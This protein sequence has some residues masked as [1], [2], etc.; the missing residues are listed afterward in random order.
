[1]AFH[2]SVWIVAGTA[3]PVVAL[4]GI[5][6]LGDLMEKNER[7]GEQAQA[8]RIMQAR[9]LT[10]AEISQRNML[11]ASLAGYSTMLYQLFIAQVV[12]VLL[13]ALLLAASLLSLLI[14]SNLVPPWLA[15]IAAFGGLVAIGIITLYL[16]SIARAMSRVIS[17]QYWDEK[18]KRSGKGSKPAR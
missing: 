6:S 11:I 13:Q 18:G 9:E 14:Q 4:A 12:N 16:G 10:D 7:F 2:E 1:V 8:L 5:V 17:M 3:A 15:V